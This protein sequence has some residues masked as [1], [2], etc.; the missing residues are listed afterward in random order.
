MIKNVN[1]SNDGIL[2]VSYT[3]DN[4]KN[5]F[6]KI[7]WINNIELNSQGHFQVTYNTKTNGQSDTYSTDLDWIKG[8]KIDNEGTIKL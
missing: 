4:D 2:T 7:K 1:L 5:T 8:I 6:P 3:H